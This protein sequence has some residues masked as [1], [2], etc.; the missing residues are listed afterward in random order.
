MTT[1]LAWHFV[2]ADMCTAYGK[3]QVA[4]GVKHHV[5]PPI[6][7]CERGL[8]ASPRI[9]DAL[10]FCLGPVVCR[11]RLSGEIVRGDSKIVATDREVLWLVNA[12]RALRWFA[13][14][15][16]E[17]QIRHRMASRPIDPRITACIEAARGYLLGRVPLDELV[18][19]KHAAAH[20]ATV[21]AHA[22]YAYYAADSVVSVVAA[23]AADAATSVVADDATERAWQSRRLRQ[24]I[25]YERRGVTMTE[26]GQQ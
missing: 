24:L 12:A 13:V 26:W 10:S 14:D 9:L 19:A 8:H 15:C 11:V 20:A 17:R 3:L 4:V 25:G 16:R 5:D 22:Y 2:P 1:I 21:A 23:D 7:M 6:V 18:A